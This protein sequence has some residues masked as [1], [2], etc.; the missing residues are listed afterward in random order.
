M[1]HGIRLLGMF[2]AL[3]VTGAASGDEVLTSADGAR[4]AFGGP[5]TGFACK[6][7][8]FGK[9]DF[10]HPDE[11]AATGL[12]RLTF[13]A[14]PNGEE[15]TLDASALKGGSCRKTESGLRFVWKGLSLDPDD[16]TVDVACGIDRNDA[17]HRYEF[18]IQ[19]RNRSA[20]YGLFATEYPRLPQVIRPGSGWAVLPGGN[21]GAFRV[22]QLDYDHKDAY[23]SWQA[24][25]QFAAF[26]ADAGEGLMVAA[27]D[28]DARLKFLTARKDFFFSVETPA[29]NAGVP[30]A[31]GAPPFTVA[32]YPYRGNWWKAAKLYRKWAQTTRWLAKGPIARRADF[33]ARMRNA[34]LWMRMM[35]HGALA[36]SE[37]IL[38]AE[39]ERIGGRVPL[40]VHWYNWQKHPHDVLYPEYFPAQEGFAEI[41]ARLR[42]KGVFVMPY[43]NARIWDVQHPGFGAVRSS[44]CQKPDGSVYVERWNERDF[45]A[46][47]QSTSTWHDEVVGIVGRLLKDYRV[48]SVYLDQV[49]SMIPVVCYAG[50]HGHSR[51][52]GRH[53]VG[54][55]VRMVEDIRAAHPGVPLTSENF[56]EPYIGSFDGFLTWSPNYP[57]DIPGIPAVYSGYAICFG[58]LAIEGY[59]LETF[60]Q[61]V[62]RCF[63]WGGQ[64]GWLEEWLL[65]DA[66]RDKF[67][68]LVRLAELR[69]GALEY[70]SDGELVG[71]VANRAKVAKLHQK[72]ELWNRKVDADFPAVMAMRWRA[73]SGKE[74]VVVANYSNAEQD[75]DGGTPALRCRLAGGEVKL[76]S[77][78]RTGYAHGNET[79]K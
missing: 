44:A 10:V 9:S 19:V 23:P 75:F 69:A 15:R 40:S 79:D 74:M 72:W 27:L 12:W 28:G 7:L 29:E 59:D 46:M 65:E 55:Y 48:D 77:V 51:G 21:W 26:D 61:L 60:R 3:A 58:S 14:G 37:R 50:D 33:P 24:T 63:L 20:K 1:E 25:M 30:G 49:A 52:G 66:H 42:A 39:L 31:A 47:C 43:V 11:T 38:N 62:G 8:S 35:S 4:L 76:L 57:E 6:S 67:D 41:V 22:R 54:D 73:P 18:R 13:R 17:E 78:K 16:G 32:L 71:E 36:E 70:F 2:A 45:A 68:Y 64:C 56:S 5:E 53:W 34:G